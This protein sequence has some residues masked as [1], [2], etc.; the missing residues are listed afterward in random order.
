MN[1]FV[2]SVIQTSL[3]HLPLDLF[4]AGGGLIEEVVVALPSP[5]VMGSAGSAA[6]AQNREIFYLLWLAFLGAAGKTLGAWGIYTLSHRLEGAA[7]NKFGKVF[8]VSH[9]QV[10]KVGGYFTR[11][12]KDLGI[13]F[14]LRILPVIPSTVLS[15]ACG[16]LKTDS[17]DFLTATFT[18]SIFRN[19]LYLYLG[20]QGL[21]YYQA[22]PGSHELFRLIING[23]VFLSVISAVIWI[24]HKKQK[25]PLFSK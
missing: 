14:L 5:L 20:Y 8:G 18:G 11:S 19:F 2:H 1:P 22:I 9:E 23:L 17:R 24:F 12:W 16:I 3:Q 7:M 25:A 13:I 4:C 6:F 15:F 21:H 10:G